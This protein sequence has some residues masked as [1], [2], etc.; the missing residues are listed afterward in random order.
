MVK[1]GVLTR[2]KSLDATNKD[3]IKLIE[4][5]CRKKYHNSTL[6]LG[7]SLPHELESTSFAVTPE[8]GFLSEPNTAIP[9][10]FSTNRFP[11]ASSQFFPDQRKAS[12]QYQSFESRHTTPFTVSELFLPPIKDEIK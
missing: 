8:P 3:A 9:T 7:S 2:Q 1:R 11:Q 4:K 6:F 12:G 5:Y 10:T